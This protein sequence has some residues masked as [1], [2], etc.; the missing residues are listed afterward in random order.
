MTLE[1]IRAAD[2]CGSLGDT[3]RNNNE[4]KLEGKQDIL[5]EHNVSFSCIPVESACGLILQSKDGVIL[6]KLIV[7]QMLRLHTI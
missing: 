4:K 1:H 3:T 2:V 5:Y 7:K 6:S